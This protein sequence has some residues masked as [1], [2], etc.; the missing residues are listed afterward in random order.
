MEKETI[1]ISIED[2][3]KIGLNWEDICEVTGYS[4]Y[5]MREGLSDKT[6]V[7][8]PIDLINK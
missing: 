4:I 6:I 3:L 2:A 7:K 8:L 5:A 1:N